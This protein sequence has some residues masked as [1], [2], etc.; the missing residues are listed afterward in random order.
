GGGLNIRHGGGGGGGLGGAI[1]NQGGTLR[2][3]NCTL[4]GNAA[5]GG[6]RGSSNS[7]GGT[8][9]QAGEGRGGAVFTRN[10]IAN[11]VGCTLA[12]NTAAQGGGGLVA[13]GD[14]ALVTLIIDN[15][16][17]AD[18]VAAVEDLQFTTIDMG[19]VST[20]GGTNVIESG[21][22]PGFGSIAAVSTDPALSTLSDNGGPTQTHALGVTAVN[23]TGNTTICA[24]AFPAGTAGV[25]QRGASRSG[26]PGGICDPG[27]YERAIEVSLSASVNTG[28]EVAGTVITLTATAT[29]A[30]L[31]DQSVTIAV[32][33]AGITA[34][35]FTL[36]NTNI[37]ILD[38]QTTG[39]ET[40]TVLSDVDI[41]G[42]ETA[43]VS[44][45]SVSAGLLTGSTL[46]QDIVI[47][48]PIVAPGFSKSFSP[49]L[50]ASTDVSQLVLTIDNIGSGFAATN[51]QVIDNFPA[52][53]VIANPA[54][55]AVDC[56]GGTLTA[57]AGSTSVSYVGGSLPALPS[58]R[59]SVDVRSSVGRAFLNITADL[60]SS[61]G[62]SGSASALLNVDADVDND[63]IANAV[64]NCPNTANTDQIDLDGDGL[65]N[66]C[67]DDADGDGMPNSYEI[68][69]GL[70]Q[71]NSFD[72]QAD[73]DG[74]GFTNLQEY[75]LGTDPNV[76]DEDAD[77]NGVPDVVDE[78]RM[79]LIVPNVILPILLDD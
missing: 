15:S 26:R 46:S 20:T 33:G 50:I 56:V 64:D 49:M 31:G 11:L 14:G 4:S 10:G 68:A 32:T 7:S 65:G 41:E 42:S 52:D 43:T 61:L 29:Q 73:L 24:D 27:A 51:L 25:D 39:N 23:G 76:F 37:T 55:A 54:N 12:N 70:N 60:T 59:I 69:N 5:Q 58:C 79:Q 40:F 28:S 47:S 6:S 67:D 3:N 34:T 71:L 66:V 8:Q 9:S 30:V 53:L 1:F 13:L 48:D 19:S 38:G 57:I 35:D 74:D 2:L 63:T 18:S 45:N 75:L 22:G 78:R 36:S 77:G 21:S 72:Q 16:I 44:I 17:V 62:N